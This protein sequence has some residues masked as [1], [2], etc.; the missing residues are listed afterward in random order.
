MKQLLFAFLVLSALHSNAQQHYLFAGTYDSP[1]SEGVYVYIFNSNDGT[2]REVSHI[3]I[4]NPSYLAVSAN[5]QLVYAVN[6]DADSLGKGGKVTALRFDKKKGTLSLINQQSSL[7]NHPCYITIDQTGKWIIAGN[8]SSGNFSILPI[9]KNGGLDSARQ[10]ITHSGSGPDTTRQ[11]A[12]HVHQTFLRKNN[13]DLY[14]NDL[15]TDKL[16]HYRFNGQTGKVSLP[17]M[18][19]VSVDPGSGP[20]HLDVHPNGKFVYLLGELTG[21]IYVYQDQGNGNLKEIQNNSSLPL[22]YKGPAGSADIHVSPDGKFLYVSNRGNSNSIGIFSIDSKTGMITLVD[23]QY[24]QG[25]TPR[26]FN[27][28]PTGKYLLV[29]NQNSD[30][31]V[32]FK[33][34]VN[35]GKLTD[36]GNRISVGKPVCLKWASLM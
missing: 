9:R 32:I 29:A 8:Y 7:G 10:L 36:T 5:Q 13:K 27:F 4:S 19:E 17:P 24:T 6:E 1:K 31:I 12:P 25:E 11:R 20:R 2:A 35:T 28:D 3:K 26:N 33:R 21:T 16:T 30:N 22:Y 23:H 15:G 34:D 14:V 18:Q